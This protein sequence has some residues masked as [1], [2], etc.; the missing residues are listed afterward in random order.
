MHYAIGT[1]VQGL[2]SNLQALRVRN[3]GISRAPLVS[4]VEAGSSTYYQ[5]APEEA[6]DV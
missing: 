5:E 2:R 1:A 4:L 6:D 3:V